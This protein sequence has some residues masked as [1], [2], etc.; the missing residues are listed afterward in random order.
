MPIYEYECVKCRRKS[1]IL[2]MRVSEKVE[3]TC[4]HCGST[5][6][7]RLMSRFA[8][9]RS[10]DAR[11]DAL[12]DPSKLGD[13]DEND[14][15]SVARMMRRMGSE[16]GDEFAGPEFDEA[17]NELESGGDLGGDDISDGADDDL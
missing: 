15:K 14:P 10:E 7:N 4:S 13:F 3:A 11:L 2:T 8:M 1:S 16:M 12:A 6:M 5:E 17:V 9:P